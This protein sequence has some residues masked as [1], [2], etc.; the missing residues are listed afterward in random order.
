MRTHRLSAVKK[1]YLLDYFYVLLKSTEQAR[2]KGAAFDVFKR[3]KQE[4]KLGESKYRRL[5]TEPTELSKTQERRFYYT[6]EQVIFEAKL[7]GLVREDDGQIKLT[8]KGRRGI[9]IYQEQGVAEFNRYLLPLMEGRYHAFYHII[10]FCFKVSRDSNGLLIL[11]NYSPLRLGYDKG[12]L[13]TATGI[14]AYLCALSSRL[15]RDIRQYLKRSVDLS[16]ANNR[17]VDSL[18]RVSILRESSQ[19][20]FDPRYYNAL[21]NRIRKFWLSYFLRDLYSFQ[22]SLQTFDIW[23]YRGKQFGL[24]QATEFFPGF[25][26]KLVYPT[27]I[28]RASVRSN[29]FVKVF[30]YSNSNLYVHEPK[31]E[32]AKENFLDALTESY[33]QVKRT[34]RSVFVSISQLKELVC[35]K[36]RLNEQTFSKFLQRAYHL[37]LSGQLRIGISL[38]ADRLPQETNA[39]YLKREPVSV[40]GKQRNIIA[41]SVSPRSA[42]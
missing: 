16:D 9:A 6:F 27:S 22:Y 41:I 15:E 12:L 21:L 17:L 4:H 25:S 8:N 11:P 5:T 38:E 39:M 26:G 1:F 36:L 31:W 23:T 28:V 10:S 29:D 14:E 33:F 35:F 13:T 30:E 19:D 37:N 18:R 2:H 24:L 42:T 20:E 7:Y 32:S 40:D 3:L 34:D